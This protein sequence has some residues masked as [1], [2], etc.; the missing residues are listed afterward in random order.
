MPRSRM[1]ALYAFTCGFVTMPLRSFFEDGDKSPFR[2][3]V[4][5]YLIVHEEG[6]AVF[7]TGLGAPAAS[8][9]NAMKGVAAEFDALADIGARL[10]AAGHDP[11]AVKWI[12]NSHLHS[13]HS[14]GNAALPN[15]TIVVQAAELAAARAGGEAYEGA[16][17]DA[18]H[19]VL[20]LNGEHDLYG[21][22]TVTLLPTP[23]H[24][25]GHQCARIRLEH[26]HVLLTGDCCYTRRTMDELILPR[27][28]MDREMHLQ[29]IRRLRAMRDSGDRVWFGH[30]PEQWEG[31]TQGVRLG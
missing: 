2:V 16:V 8:A 29:S 30:D 9:L 24:T 13:D 6:L 7:D 19:P 21:D 18:G 22:G 3:P 10:A 23:G 14:G 15:A 12:I 1:V 4:P 20:C 27:I 5:A 26:G 28:T 31:V 17:F 11:A 25:P